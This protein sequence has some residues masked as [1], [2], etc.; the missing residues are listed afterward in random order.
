[1]PAWYSKWLP[2]WWRELLKPQYIFG[3]IIVIVA[4]YMHIEH[5]RSINYR[6]ERYEFIGLKAKQLNNLPPINIT[7]EHMHNIALNNTP[8]PNQIVKKR[9]KNEDRCREIL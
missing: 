6:P 5:R 2:V 7:K 4:I 8:K 3:L 1:M 9:W